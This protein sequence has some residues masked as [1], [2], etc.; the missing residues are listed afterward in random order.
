MFGK[1]V[2]LHLRHLLLRNFSS[3]IATTMMAK[4]ILLIDDHALFRSGLSMVISARLETVQIHEAAS[5]DDALHGKDVVEPDIVLLDI[6]MPGLN[7]IEAI[8]LLKQKWPQAPVVMLSA[9]SAPEM[10]A[11]AMARGA[12]NFVTKAATP[13]KIIAVITHA[14]N[15]NAAA[16]SAHTHTP[17]R[18]T[19]SA[20]SAHAASSGAVATKL[21]P[22]QCEVLDLLC[23]GLSNK[24]IGQKLGLSENTVRWHVQA[25]MQALNISSRSGASFAARAQGLIG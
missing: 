14:L 9:N 1:K 5:I 8:G 15:A 17:F 25:L 16:Q 7:G 13:E 21:T 19:A 22:R 23:R 3:R 11:L 18:R 20:E 4:R 2:I 6:Q 12:A 10:V 24:A